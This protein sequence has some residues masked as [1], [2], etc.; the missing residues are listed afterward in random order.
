MSGSKRAK[1][2]MAGVSLAAMLW[3]GAGW[4]EA[5]VQ[6][7]A[8]PSLGQAEDSARSW[9]GTL[10][11][12]S[13][14]AMSTG[15]YAIALGPYADATAADEEL[16]KLRR[17]G[18]IP[19]DSYVSDGTRFGG[20][21]WPVGA[22]LSATP[23]A[24]P[25]AAEPAA[26]AEQPVAEAAAQP[27]PEPVASEPAPP[28]EPVETLADSRRIEAALS[29]EA[30]MEIQSA[31][32]WAG[33]YNSTIDGAFGRGTRASISAWQEA[34]GFEPTGVLA[35]AE[36]AQLLDTVAAERAALGLAPVEEKEAGIAIDLP[37]GLVEF[38]HYDPPFVHYRAKDGSGVTVLLISQPGDQNALFGLYD[39]MQT[40]E[41]VPMTGERRRDK[42][43][44]VLTGQN[45]RIHSHTEAKLSAGLIKGFTLVWPAGD[46]ARMTRVLEAMKASF[47]PVGDTALDPTLGK[48]MDVARG[49]LISG[50]DVRHPEFA[51]SGF[52]I[53]ANGAVLT[54]AAGLDRCGKLTIEDVPA[55]LAFVDAAL[56]A[57]VLLPQKPLAP[58]AVA[59][60]E[61]L[62]VSPGAEVTVAGFS[63]PEALSAP[64]LSFGTLS[65]LSGLGGEQSHA[66]L[67]VHTLPGDAGGPVLDGSGAVLG[68][69]LPRTADPAK[70][71][72]EDLTE[73]V[74][75]TALAPVLAEKGFAPQ[76]AEGTGTL[77][78][79]DIAAM[80]QGFTV[81]IAC[82]K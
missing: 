79:E 77:A 36:Q 37:L 49:D 56:G 29:R 44:F 51:R 41:I 21:F 35:S 12:V 34:Q 80:A 17:E 23:A 48:P 45:E 75:A 31:L 13:G 59:A 71:L 1:G 47:K 3:S 15:W 32:Q 65:D 24:P 55:K 67:A 61:T 38:D 30:R 60:F 10:P 54:A 58:P 20:Q 66:R 5:W 8:Q 7:E 28:A 78:T 33:F 42:G 14:F 53:A 64:V 27:A 40:L 25:A 18:I 74:Q 9:A 76:A 68:V 39:A 4:A 73:A 72:P 16:R 43:G 50:L 46:D 63:Y 62:P 22:A 57:A 69:V 19:R 26:P 81:Q 82:W 70:L 6:I 11:G 2:L 52:F